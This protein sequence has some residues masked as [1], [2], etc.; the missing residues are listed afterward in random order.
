MNVTLLEKVTFQ[1]IVWVILLLLPITFIGFYPSYFSILNDRLPFIHHIHGGAMLVWLFIVITQLF[2]IKYNKLSTHKQI[3]RLSYYLM[4]LI[5]VTGYYILRFSYQ[6]ALAG[7][8][9]GPPGHYPA[10]LPLSIKAAEFVVIGSVYWFWLTT[11]YLVGVYFR[12]NSVAH[13]TFMSAAAFTMLGPSGDRLIGQICD[14]FRWPYNWVAEN[15]TFTLILI[16]FIALGVR[17]TS[18]QLSLKPALM[19]LGIHIM[20]ILLYYYLPYNSFWNWF[21]SIIF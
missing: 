9:V 21:T 1:W 15:M 11:Y 2:L 5:L 4:P 19:V 12:K 8:D 20:G 10:E 16:F 3:G 6:R 7:D 18:K 17:H 13:A 14:F